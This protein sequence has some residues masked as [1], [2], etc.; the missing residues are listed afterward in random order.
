MQ[1]HNFGTARHNYRCGRAP[2]YIERQAIC[3]WILERIK[4]YFKLT[5]DHPRRYAPRMAAPCCPVALGVARNDTK[6][7]TTALYATIRWNNQHSGTALLDFPSRSIHSSAYRVYVGTWST[8]VSASQEVNCRIGILNINVDISC[9]YH[10]SIHWIIRCRVSNWQLVRPPDRRRASPHR[11]RA[12]KCA[13]VNSRACDNC[14]R[15]ASMQIGPQPA[16]RQRHWLT[17]VLLDVLC[18]AVD[19]SP[20]AELTTESTAL[21]AQNNGPPPHNALTTHVAH[22]TFP[23]FPLPN[24]EAKNNVQLEWSAIDDPRRWAIRCW[25]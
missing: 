3:V 16:G 10:C 14:S 19:C 6:K 15:H 4:A 21:M 5:E 13:P 9:R 1:I 2:S 17:R 12:A 23:F 18:Q 8:I 20:V 24:G 25:N 11:A 22:V 7:S